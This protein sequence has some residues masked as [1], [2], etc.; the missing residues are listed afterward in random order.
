MRLG[1]LP[2]GGGGRLRRFLRRLHRLV[3]RIHHFVQFRRIVRKLFIFGVDRL[4]QRRKTLLRLG[5]RFFGRIH[6]LAGIFHFAVLHLFGSVRR[7]LGG[8]GLRFLSLL[9][10]LGG[11]VGVRLDRPRLLF[12]L[13]RQLLGL[14][15]EFRGVFGQFGLSLGR[16]LLFFLRSAL[17][18]LFSLPGDLLLTLLQLFGLLG[19]FLGLLLFLVEIALEI[20]LNL[21]GE[22]LRQLLLQLGERLRVDLLFLGKFRQRLFPRGKIL[23]PLQILD[24]ARKNVKLPLG[25]LERLERLVDVLVQRGAGRALLVPARHHRHILGSLADRHDVLLKDRTENFRS[26][27]QLAVHKPGDHFRHQP[28]GVLHRGARRFDALVGL[29][30]VPAVFLG[31]PETIRRTA[32]RLLCPPEMRGDVLDILLAGVDLLLQRLAL[33]RSRST[34]GGNHNHHFARICDARTAQSRRKIVFRPDAEA[35][36]SGIAYL[37]REQMHDIAAEPGHIAVLLRREGFRI[38]P[39]SG[40]DAHLENR[41]RKPE[42]VLDRILQ[43]QHPGLGEFHLRFLGT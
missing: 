17:G 42:V 36:H 2:L 39:G 15:S 9:G 27:F 19:E 41:A 1:L 40:A 37:L 38:L 30:A 21:L 32:E 20:V 3:E 16:R 25:F 26:R 18:R 29:V 22:F 10:V 6:I 7:L 28:F 11:A 31:V 13:P 33:K 34:A 12:N 5:K 14:L 43:R 24:L 23:K 35:D 8:L 4:L